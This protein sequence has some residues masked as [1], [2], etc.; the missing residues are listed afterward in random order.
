[1]DGPVA[2]PV[3]KEHPARAPIEAHPD[4]Y[5]GQVSQ[6]RAT[7]RP[8]GDQRRVEGSATQPAGKAKQF[9]GS[10][11]QAFLVVNDDVV[12]V[13]I[14]PKQIRRFGPH[15]GSDAAGAQPRPGRFDQRGGQH[16]VAHECGL[17]DENAQPVGIPGR[18][19]DTKARDYFLSEF[20]NAW[21]SPSA[22]R[23]VF[24]GPV[25]LRNTLPSGA[26]MMAPSI[27]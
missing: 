25:S 18:N 10:F 13:G 11:L 3:R 12:D 4:G 14:V 20:N 1:M 7:E 9:Q 16:E 26:S 27:L 17:Y 19:A 23:T 8:V 6:Q 24:S 21:N 15:Y 22:P 2:D 5:A